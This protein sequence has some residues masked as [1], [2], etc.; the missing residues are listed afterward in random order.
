MVKFLLD[1][2]VLLNN[3]RMKGYVSY[4]V[5]EELDR[6]KTKPELGKPARDAI[7]RIYFNAEEYPFIEEETKENE[8][9]DDYLVRQAQEKNLILLTYDLSLFLKAQSKGINV[10]FLAVSSEDYTGVTYTDDNLLGRAFTGEDVY[11]E[12]HFLIRGKDAYIIRDGRPKKIGYRS[13]DSKFANQIT[14]RN[15]EQY[16]AMELIL[17]TTVPVVSITGGFGSGKSYLILTYA[18]SELMKGKYDRLIVVP[19][20]AFV[21]DSREIAAVPGG[22]LEKEYMHLGPLIDLLGMEGIAM[23]T[24]NPKGGRIELMPISIARGRNLENTLVWV[25]ESQNLT[26]EHIL[27]LLGRIGQNTRIFFDGDIKQ[28]DKNIFK[29]RSGLQLLNKIAKTD[30]SNLFGHVRLKEIERSEVAKLADLLDSLR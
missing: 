21:S 10:E 14:P 25:S 17:D 6:L 24:N 16:C 19:N 1:T 8:A 29:S 18:L 20:N 3:P 11:P 7:L 22:L 9:V 30:K 13:Y 15:I 5:L 12:N 26:E 2:N 27:L 28:A 4:P 23:F